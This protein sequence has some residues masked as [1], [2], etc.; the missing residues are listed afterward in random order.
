VDS[1]HL[2]CL[3]ALGGVGDTAS[4][5]PD[6]ILAV[7]PTQLP[8]SVSRI[9]DLTALAVVLRPVVPGSGS[10]SGFDQNCSAVLRHAIGNG[11]LP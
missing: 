11:G 10:A 6:A 4:E 9:R 5:M 7:R 3:G 8:C 2:A 1:R